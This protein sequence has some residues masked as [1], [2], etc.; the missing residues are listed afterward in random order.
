MARTTVEQLR[1]T[2]SGGKLGGVFFLYGDEEYLKED[3]TALLIRSHLDPSTRDFNFDQLFAD[4]LE[5]E[6]L[7]SITSTP[8]M[9]AEWRVVVV[10]EAQALAASA[11]SRA[12][13]EALLERSVPGLA[14]ILVASL[15]D[16]SKAA[17]YERLKKETTSLDFPLLDAGDVPAWLTT[18]AE[19]RGVAIDTAA[20]RSLAAAIGSDLG[21][22]S[23]ELAKLIEYV[24]DRK[25]IAK[26]DVE[27]V[28]GIVP[29]QNRWEWFDLVGGG[30]IGEARRAIPILLDAGESGV[31][32]VIGLGTHM[33]R[34]AIAAAGGERALSDALPG[35]QKFLASR[36]VRQ[37][38]AWSQEG[39]MLALDDLLRADRLLKSTSLG[40]HAILEE[41]LLRFEQYTGRKA[42]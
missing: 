29:Q 26:A 2:L 4:K 42:A 40:E 36:I 38:R 25:K 27:A 30:N 20:A 10:R 21:V 22:L 7:A 23:Q 16:R 35:H 8:P 3:A 13:I 34:V 33:L 24:G 41:L 6:T 5:P 39:T 12:P 28:V 19:E 15:P 17:F 37:A 1:K 14:L 32:L 9:M 18:R 11:R 31:G